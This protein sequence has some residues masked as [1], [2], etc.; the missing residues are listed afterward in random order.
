MAD[1]KAWVWDRRT[2]KGVLMVRADSCWSRE[3]QVFELKDSISSAVHEAFWNVRKPRV[4]TESRSGPLLGLK[5]TP[6][7]LPKKFSRMLKNGG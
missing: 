2:G 4:S 5:E 6:G 7:R 3:T 1:V